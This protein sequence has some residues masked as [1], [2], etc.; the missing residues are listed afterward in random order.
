M[1]RNLILVLI[2]ITAMYVAPVR[3]DTCEGGIDIGNLNIGGSCTSNTVDPALKSDLYRAMAT[4]AA[5]TNQLPEQVRSAGPLPSTAG[6]AQ[7]FG[8]AK[9]VFSA[10]SRQ[11]LLGKTLAPLGETL[12][13]MLSI[14]I[15]M[16]AIYMAIRI[17]V[18]IIKAVV[19]VV[20]QFLKL[21]P[22][23]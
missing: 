14:G 22:F 16:T 19:W 9:W 10:N 18:L 21:I 5:S 20:N 12:W 15:V 13:A 4:A 2:F 7:I 11:E 6:A 3:A 1:P 23:W 17:I 8:Y